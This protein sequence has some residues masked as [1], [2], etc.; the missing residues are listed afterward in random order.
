M[1]VKSDYFSYYNLPV[2]S[3][4][5][6]KSLSCGR[7]HEQVISVGINVA[8]WILESVVCKNP[9]RSAGYSEMLKPTHLHKQP[10]HSQSHRN[11]IFPHL[12]CLMWF[13]TLALV[14]HDWIIECISHSSCVANMY[15]SSRI[16]ISRA[17]LFSHSLLSWVH[18]FV[19]YKGFINIPASFVAVLYLN[20]PVTMRFWTQLVAMYSWLCRG[21]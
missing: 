2:C 9:K 18:S 11:H 6:G 14:L 13:C 12:W 19:V 5:S 17:E 8:H 1:I 7:S 16:K 20:W 4:H 15:E 3:C 21:E 10:C